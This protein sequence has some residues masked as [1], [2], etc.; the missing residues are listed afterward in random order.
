[1]K[2]LNFTL[3]ST[4]SLS[5]LSAGG[6]CVAKLGSLGSHS[7]DRDVDAGTLQEAARRFRACGGVNEAALSKRRD[8]AVIQSHKG[9][10]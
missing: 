9:L 10:R 6:Y 4:A 3:K 2:N 5:Q 8:S 7:R 1:M